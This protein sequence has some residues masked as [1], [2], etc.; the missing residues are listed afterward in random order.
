MCKTTTDW[1]QMMVIGATLRD[2]QAEFAHAQFLDISCYNFFC[3]VGSCVELVHVHFNM[4]RTCKQLLLSQDFCV[5]N[6]ILVLQS[7]SLIV[8]WSCLICSPFSG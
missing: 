7:L 3:G 5:F 2:T 4:W 1:F 8:C 6:R